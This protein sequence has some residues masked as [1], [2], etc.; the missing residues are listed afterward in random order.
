MNQKCLVLQPRMTQGLS[1]T[2]S[3]GRQTAW[4]RAASLHGCIHGVPLAD[5]PGSPF[6]TKECIVTW[7]S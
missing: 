7:T 6:S 2:S 1:G 4:M 5:V 3:G